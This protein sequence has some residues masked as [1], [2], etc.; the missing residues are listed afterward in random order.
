MGHL[1]VP[2]LNIIININGLFKII[3][4]MSTLLG[5]N[6]EIR[7]NQQGVSFA[8]YSSQ[9]SKIELCLFDSEDN[10]KRFVMKKK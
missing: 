8:L 7:N 4:V 10:E 2:F 5:A 3:I 1:N 9:A 6:I